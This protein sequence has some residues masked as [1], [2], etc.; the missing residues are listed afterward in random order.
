MWEWIA[1]DRTIADTVSVCVTV[2]VG[3]TSGYV[4]VRGG[5]LQR[6]NHTLD[7]IAP[8]LLHLAGEL[9]PIAHNLVHLSIDR[10]ARCARAS[11]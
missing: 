9:V 8:L 4:L 2:R 7:A 10:I 1:E 6:M 5:W 3:V 11:A